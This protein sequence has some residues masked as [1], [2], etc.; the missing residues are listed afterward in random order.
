M[1]VLPLPLTA[2]AALCQEEA[3]VKYHRYER[4]SSFV[5]RAMRMPEVSET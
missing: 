2:T 4:S 1:H 3:G 5:G